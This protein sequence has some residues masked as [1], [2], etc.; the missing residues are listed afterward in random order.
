MDH[1][2]VQ[3]SDRSSVKVR[4]LEDARQMQAAITVAA[5]KAGKAPPKYVLDELIGRGSFG[6]VY[7]G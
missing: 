1:L 2:Q 5:N 6:R 3:T 4:A 7:R